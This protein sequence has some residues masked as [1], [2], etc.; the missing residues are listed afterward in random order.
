MMNGEKID[1]VVAVAVLYRPDLG[2]LKKMVDSLHHQV[3][4]LV[5][6]DNTPG[7]VGNN[8]STQA[9]LLVNYPNVRYIALGENV[10]IAKAQNIGIELAKELAADYVLLM[11]QDSELPPEFVESLLIT[12]KKVDG[13]LKGGRPAAAVGPAFV[14]VK[15]GEYAD[16][17][18]HEGLSVKKINIK[19]LVEPVGVDFIIASGSLISM[20][21]MAEIGLMRGDFFIDWVDIEWGLRA[22]SL[23]Y[24]IYIDPRTVMRHSIGDD[25]VSFAGRGVNLHSDFRNY[26]IVRNSVYM[27]A[28]TAVPIGWKFAQLWK[29][30]LYVFFYSWH[31]KHKAYSLKLLFRAVWDGI[32][33]NMGAGYFASMR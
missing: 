3:V 28:H 18:R 31:S 14:D 26:F 25:T 27:I 22:N 1:K 5:V 29:T 17:I 9:I 23:N 6:I 10:G 15:T 24:A 20:T 19:G 7:D 2:V 12:F 13:K 4:H 21:A 8:N 11:D 16:A 32:A 33:G 30:P